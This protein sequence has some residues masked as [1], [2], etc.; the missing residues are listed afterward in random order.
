[1]GFAR[2]VAIRARRHA[3]QKRQAL[4]GAD[5]LE[6]IHEERQSMRRLGFG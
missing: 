3:L 4:F 5:F 6:H 1:M 2:D